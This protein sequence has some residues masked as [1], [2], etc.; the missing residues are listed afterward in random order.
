MKKF[1]LIAA[2]LMAFTM[3]SASTS[4]TQVL[5]VANCNQSVTLRKSPSVYADEIT[6]IPLGQGVVIIDEAENGFYRVG[7]GKYDGYVLADYLSD[8]E[9]DNL[10]IGMMIDRASLFESY[11]TH[12]PKI[13]EIASGNWVW[14]IGDAYFSR[15][16]SP[17]FYLVKAPN[18]TYG[19]ILADRVDWN[20]R[21][22][23]Q[24]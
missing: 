18:G 14:Y 7:Y 24:N 1:V 21:G 15:P 19:Y 9:P 6:Q 2:F 16:E 12:S 13:M 4:A 20:Y 11:S 3:F 10:K 5:F 8:E 23:N 22:R 17:D